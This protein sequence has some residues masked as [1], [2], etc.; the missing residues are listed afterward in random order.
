MRGNFPTISH[1]Y[2]YQSVPFLSVA[3]DESSAAGITT[4]LDQWN[5]ER[6]VAY[7]FENLVRQSNATNI[8]RYFSRVNTIW[9]LSSVNTLVR[10]ANLQLEHHYCI[11]NI[12]IGRFLSL[13]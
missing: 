6:C 1:F 11:E 2:L 5:Q 10:C 8:A 4:S 13:S 7:I 9:F 12:S 3:L